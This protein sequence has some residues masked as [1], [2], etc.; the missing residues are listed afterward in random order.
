MIFL[1][2]SILSGITIILCFK[3]ADRA[4]L[5]TFTVI[6]LNYLTAFLLGLVLTGKE[7]IPSVMPATGEVT[8]AFAIGILFVVL[9]R[10][11]G[12]SVKTAG[13]GIS[14]IAAKI[15][16]AIPITFSI[17]AYHET[18]N[19]QKTAGI[20]LALV[21]LVFTIYRK[22]KREKHS[23]LFPVLLFVGMGLVDSMVKYVQAAHLINRNILVF[24][25]WV[26]LIA[27][28]TGLFM[29]LIE[30]K[31]I[32][33]GFSLHLLGTGILLG[34]ANLGSLYFFIRTL[35]TGILDSSLIFTINNLGILILTVLTG[36]LFFRERLNRM[37]RIGFFLSLVS[38][39]IIFKS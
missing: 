29:K 5:N 39:Y 7:L 1:L 22:G 23:I 20:L 25:T 27:F 11:L 3:W 19:F 33:K 15:S 8:A 38:L 13:M 9:F 12:V 17:A 30:K 16:V 21:S 35:N 10:I 2:L 31:N 34:T 18:L 24:S 28:I 14:T 6:I 26:F 32:T 36:V 4:G 37:N